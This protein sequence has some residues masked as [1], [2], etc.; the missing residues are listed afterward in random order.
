MS[1]IILHN[2]G[3]LLISSLEEYSILL[4][5]SIERTMMAAT[6]RHLFVDFISF[7]ME[8]GGFYVALT[9]IKT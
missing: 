1:G 7:V 8:Y 6:F 3:S 5:L 9:R 2:V 4:Y